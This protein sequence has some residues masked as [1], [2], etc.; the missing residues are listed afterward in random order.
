MHTFVVSA[1]RYV[2]HVF[3]DNCICVGLSRPDVYSPMSNMTTFNGSNDPT[4]L[5]SPMALN[6]SNK[7]AKGVKLHSMSHIYAPI[8]MT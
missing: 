5:V 7:D 3:D 2:I 1:S 4:E 8:G 6:E